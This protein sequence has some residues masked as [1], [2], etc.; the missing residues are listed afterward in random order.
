MPEAW[1]LARVTIIS[2][3][4]L[5]GFK[6]SRFLFSKRRGNLV[7]VR[8][9]SGILSLVKISIR[10]LRLEVG[11]GISE[12]AVAETVGMCQVREVGQAQ[13]LW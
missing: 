4:K 2:C 8:W 12:R 13:Q 1:S 6:Q 9:E 5:I 11:L 3:L 10:F 7:S